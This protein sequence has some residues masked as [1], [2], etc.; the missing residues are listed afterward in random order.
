MTLRVPVAKIASVGMRK[1]GD[2]AVVKK[3]MET[4][5][6][7]RGSSAPCGAAVPRNTKPRSIPAI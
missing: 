2:P 1:L 4:V 7:A 3:A 6:A 5:A